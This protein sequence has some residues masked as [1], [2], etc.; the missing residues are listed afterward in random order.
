[1]SY[2]RVKKTEFFTSFK[3]FWSEE[4]LQFCSSR[5]EGLYNLYVHL[6]ATGCLYLEGQKRR[7]SG[8]PSKTVNGNV[9]HLFNN[10]TNIILT[11]TC[12]MRCP[13]FQV[14]VW[15]LVL[16]TVSWILWVTRSWRQRYNSK[17]HCGFYRSSTFWH[18]I[19]ICLIISLH[20]WFSFS[21]LSESCP[22][23]PTL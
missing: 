18:F 5:L 23:W 19:K 21:V 8:T 9:S 1:M 10:D 13:C 12:W 14:Q 22:Y 4:G 11:S 6:L 16:F 15:L 7:T 17:S 3:C 2:F 20:V